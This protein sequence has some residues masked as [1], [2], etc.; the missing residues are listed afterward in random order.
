MNNNAGKMESMI[1]VVDLTI[2]QTA[3]TE[4]A[5]F[6][7]QIRNQNRWDSS[8]RR[9][10]LEKSEETDLL[11]FFL[12]K[13]KRKLKKKLSNFQTVKGNDLLEWVIPHNLFSPNLQL[14]YCAWKKRV[15]LFILAT[16]KEP[17]EATFWKFY[18]FL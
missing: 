13:R 17:Y 12:K 8:D 16:A 1:P 10:Q 6:R 15:Q 7:C 4:A 9:L 3:S 11:F 2:E 14:N 5:S 18:Y